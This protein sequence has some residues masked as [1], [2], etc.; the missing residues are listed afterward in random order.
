[1]ENILLIIVVALRAIIA[2]EW[3]VGKQVPSQ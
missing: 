1:M 2:A 3:I